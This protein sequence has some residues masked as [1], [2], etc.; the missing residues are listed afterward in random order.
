MLKVWTCLQ[1]QHDWRLVLV[2]GLVCFLTCLAAVNLHQRARAV[3]TRPSVGWLLAAG[4]VTGGGIWATH[5]IAMLA[6]VPG[7]DFDFD[8][9][10]TVASLIV[11]AT[12]TTLGL[13]VAA[14]LPGSR[15]TVIG[16]GLIGAGIGC[17]HYM[18]MASLNFVILWDWP[19]VAVSLLCALVGSIGAV[20][21]AQR[22]ETLPAL[23]GAAG[24]LALAIL[25]HHFIAMGAMDALPPVTADHAA[26]RIEPLALCLAI[27]AATGAIIVASL[28]VAL[29]DRSTHRR[30][31]ER[32][33]QLDVALN[34]MGRGLCMFDASG[35]VQLCNSEYLDMYH[36]RGHD[37]QAGVDYRHLLQL[38]AQVGT[39]PIDAG[40]HCARL[41]EAIAERRPME[42]MTSLADGRQIHVSY[43]PVAHGGWVITHEDYT[44]RMQ[45]RSRI[46]FLAH[47]D[48]LTQLPNRSAF[49]KQFDEAII[50]ANKARSNFATICIDLDRFKEINDVYGH[51][52][53]DAFLCE[54]AR[55][56]SAAS[57]DAFVARIG[58]DEFV[59]IAEGSE[60][61][62]AAAELCE[63]ILR[64]F[65]AEF[66]LKGCAIKG[67][68]SIG[69]AIYPDNGR[70]AEE[71]LANADAALYRVKADQRGS[72]RFFE[73]ALDAS[74]REKRMLQ[75]ELAEAVEAGQFEPH[76]QPQVNA[77]GEVVG[78]EVLGRWR[79]PER[80]LVAPAL[81]IGLAEETGL[82]GGI[83]EQI[84]RAACR[85]AASW[86]KPLPIA[87][88]LSPIDFR[89]GDVPS[90][91][92]SILFET[93]L[94]PGRLHI[95]ITEGVLMQDDGRVMSQLRRIK[96]LGAHL[97]LDDF[98][99]GYSSL[100]Y[101]QAFPFDKLKIDR[102]FVAQLDS[103]PQSRAIVRAIIGL[104]H[105]LGLSV[106][107]EGVETDDQLDV[108]TGLG[109]DE[110]QGYL[111]GRPQPFR[112]YRHLT[113]SAPASIA[114]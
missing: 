59:I 101:L 78:F 5:F 58:G 48:G 80:G 49:D 75:M 81:F 33:L 108:L 65:D 34:N 52:V 32:N 62:A 77:A 89:R 6:Y 74:L 85:E 39:S 96:S 71:L 2:A 10:M 111:T 83:D 9:T 110:F 102:A 63:R 69:V 84:L 11:A 24:L 41:A 64:A 109:C 22:G 114:V 93:G 112:L 68:C 31:T 82:I 8:L 57:E 25:S 26:D 1:T 35:R 87:V 76:Y 13:S 86:E 67:N 61:P 30:I 92:L 46:E 99:T 47:H 66:L 88:N 51:G 40:T 100:S 29:I 27:A 38:K 21:L 20:A 113:R 12:M 106:I 97:A 90:M 56:L 45:N 103:N 36:L 19:I 28:F 7:F 37:L 54:V 91:I 95:E 50:R 18:G 42:W 44:E 94:S 70:A 55:R 17:M 3:G 60:Q 43:R 98:G 72:Y 73:T 14:C 4:A 107:A 16:G 53:G 23:T 105:T 15:G 104:G 79:H